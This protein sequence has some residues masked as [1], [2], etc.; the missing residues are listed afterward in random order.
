ML[1]LNCPSCAATIVFK[2]RVSV[3]AVCSYCKSAVVRHDL[4]VENL[5]KMAELPPDM[6]P[7]QL[8]TRGK[9]EGTSFEI[10]G[11]LKVAWEEG[12]WNEWYLLF[13]SGRDGWLA[14][15]QG[16]YGV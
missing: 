8:G 12:T 13:D 11:R 1:K 7:L 10:V 3:L 4:N 6:S 16:F 5:G 14:E 15:A 2:S 9:Y